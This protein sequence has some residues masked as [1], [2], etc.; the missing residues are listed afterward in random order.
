[1]PDRCGADGLDMVEKLHDL[2]SGLEPA[3]RLGIV[4]EE[5]VDAVRVV[6]ARFVSK[7][8]ERISGLWVRMR[9]SVKNSLVW[10]TDLVPTAIFIGGHGARV[11][12]DE[13]CVKALQHDQ[14]ILCL[15]RQLIFSIWWGRC[16]RFQIPSEPDKYPDIQRLH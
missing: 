2:R 1:V 9:I 13:P 11:I 5:D 6:L 8:C 14:S 12:Y 10:G 7:D 15:R 4:E 3:T 16:L